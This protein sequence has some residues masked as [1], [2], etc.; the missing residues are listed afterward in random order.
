MRRQVDADRS[1]LH[2]PSFEATSNSIAASGGGSIS[3]AMKA[4]GPRWQELFGNP[5]GFVYNARQAE[6]HDPLLAGSQEARC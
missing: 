4:A 6:N 5:D 1:C 2:W 3:G